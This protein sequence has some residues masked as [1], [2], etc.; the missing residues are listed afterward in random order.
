MHCGCLWKWSGELK[1]CNVFLAWKRKSTKKKT[2]KKEKNIDRN[3]VKKK[4]KKK[5]KC[6]CFNVICYFDFVVEVMRRSWWSYICWSC[7]WMLRRSDVEVGSSPI[8][9]GFLAPHGHKFSHLYSMSLAQFEVSFEGLLVIVAYIEFIW[10]TLARF[11]NFYEIIDLCWILSEFFHI[12]FEC[13]R[14]THMW[15]FD[16]WWRHWFELLWLYD[17]SIGLILKIVIHVVESFYFCYTLMI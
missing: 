2:R 16:F 3:K 5:Y 13:K 15:G 10:N 1:W 9:P 12:S 8:F 14:E 7:W 6:L 4:R 11:D 17:D